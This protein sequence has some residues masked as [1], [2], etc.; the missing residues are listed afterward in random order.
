VL[1]ILTKVNAEMATTALVIAT[2]PPSAPWR[3]G[4]LALPTV[5]RKGRLSA[6]EPQSIV[7]ECP[8]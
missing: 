6:Q 3:I 2:T 8:Q 4:W 5:E 1:A 7:P